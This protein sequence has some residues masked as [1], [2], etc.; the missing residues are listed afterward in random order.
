MGKQP[1]V[2]EHH[3][4]KLELL[5]NIRAELGWL[6]PYFGVRLA[7]TL[8]QVHRNCPCNLPVSTSAESGPRQK[9]RSGC[10]DEK[11]RCGKTTHSIRDDRG[12]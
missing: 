3:A 6:C 5:I 8:Q 1:F 7:R 9:P 10:V 12:P 11:T 4:D 2:W